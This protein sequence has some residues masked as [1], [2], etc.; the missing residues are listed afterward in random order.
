MA[1]DSR[2][3]GKVIWLEGVVIARTADG[4]QRQLKIG[5]VVFEGES[6]EAA[7]D[8]QVE[9]AFEQ[10]GRFLLRAKESVTLDAALFDNGFGDDRQEGGLLNRVAE[11]TTGM[12]VETQG[13]PGRNG[14]D[15]NGNGG[16]GDGTGNGGDLVDRVR[17]DDG[18]SF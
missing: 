5:D 16:N 11:N 9:F 18:N 4:R 8:A 1:T 7:A 13:L 15:S 17:F 12:T 3:I 6:I 14:A 10:G 2:G